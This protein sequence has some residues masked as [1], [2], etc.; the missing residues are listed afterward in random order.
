[1]CIL[2]THEEKCIYKQ[3]KISCALFDSNINA[4]TRHRDSPEN[5][6][7]NEKGEYV[8]VIGV[9]KRIGEPR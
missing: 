7:N 9:E 2:I 1:M 4:P 5:N 3:N 8:N 6:S